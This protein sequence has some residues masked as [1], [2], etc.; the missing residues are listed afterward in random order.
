MDI[1]YKHTIYRIITEDLISHKMIIPFKKFIY[2]V[3]QGL[4]KK[5]YYDF[6]IFRLQSCNKELKETFRIFYYDCLKLHEKQPIVLSYLKTINVDDS[7]R[8]HSRIINE[9]TNNIQ[10]FK[11]K[12]KNN[13]VIKIFVKPIKDDELKLYSFLKAHLDKMICLSDGEDCGELKIIRNKIIRLENVTYKFGLHLLKKKFTIDAEKLI[14]EQKIDCNLSIADYKFKKTKK[15]IKQNK[16]NVFYIV[17]KH[18]YIIEYIKGEIGHEAKIFIFDPKKLDKD[19]TKSILIIYDHIDTTIKNMQFLKIYAFYEGFAQKN[20]LINKL[21]KLNLNH[22]ASCSTNKIIE[23]TQKNV[24]KYFI[25]TSRATVNFDTGYLMLTNYFVLLQNMYKDE[26]FF[27]KN[28]NFN[29]SYEEKNGSFQCSLDLPTVH[30]DFINI[31]SSYRLSKNDARKCASLKALEF[32]HSNGFMDDFLCPIKEKLINQN[33]IFFQTIFKVYN[34]KIIMKECDTEVTSAEILFDYT[35]EDINEQDTA[36]DLFFTQIET[37]GIDNLKLK[38][39]IFNIKNKYY[40]YHMKESN[41]TLTKIKTMFEK[42]HGV[43]LDAKEELY[44]NKFQLINFESKQAEVFKTYN[45]EMY[46]YEFS[47][48]KN[49]K[50]NGNSI[51]LGIAIGQSFTEKIKIQDFEIKNIQMMRI[52]EA[53]IKCLIFF[54]VILFM[55][56]FK[57]I[58]SVKGEVK[59]YCYFY[60]PL[61]NGKVDIEYILKFSSVDFLIGSV[62]ENYSSVHLKENFLYNPFTKNFYLFEKASERDI[63]EVEVFNKGEKSFYDYFEEKYNTKLLLKTGNNLLFDGFIY[64]GKES[65]ISNVL[66]AEIMQI[67]SIKKE[68]CANFKKSKKFI[69]LLEKACLS[70]EF[71]NKHDLIISDQITLQCFLAKDQEYDNYE[72][73]EFLGDSLLKFVAVKYIFL[74]DNDSLGNV[75]LRKDKF[76]SNETLFLIAKLL[77]IPSYFS[78]TKYSETL[79]QPPNLLMYIEN[80]QNKDLKLECENYIDYFEAKKLFQSKNVTYQE[81]KV[82]QED[83]RVKGLKTY[84]D[85]VEALIGAHFIEFG[86][87][88]GEE[89]IHAIGIFDYNKRSNIEQDKTLKPEVIQKNSIIKKQKNKMLNKENIAKYSV[90]YS[91]MKVFYDEYIESQSIKQMKELK[92]ILK[93]TEINEI[94]KILNYQFKYPGLIEKAMIHP[95]SHQNILGSNNFN[96]LEFLGDCALDIVVTEYIYN[97]YKAFDPEGMHCKR[98]SLVNNFSLARVLFKTNLNKYLHICFNNEHINVVKEKLKTDGENVNKAFGDVFESICGAILVDMNYCIVAFK[99]YIIDNLFC[100]IQVCADVT[101]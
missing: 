13:N 26:F 62:Y 19:I 77:Q 98:K 69:F 14:E 89:F 91:K 50:N 17:I 7:V 95:S 87:I 67:T 75:V 68:L 22:K 71:K 84:A 73:L 90:D 58:K 61:K 60:V 54:Q 10:S 56:N 100:H 41:F 39:V 38:E 28:L 81:K 37:Y 63:N 4:I 15:I 52:T 85:I 2:L 86:Y 64:N 72:R 3:R 36:K 6:V 27:L 99:S 65:G 97:T 16:E 1:L 5:E 48:G 78:F 79:F 24:E 43:I 18:H 82:P 94:E 92:N 25:P 11:C 35:D 51:N 83:D 57:R 44:K 74:T 21:L 70:F 46:I 80:L 32:L 49:K 101:R 23:Y 34:I 29:D 40:E 96:K 8:L 12:E 59:D 42:E 30:I 53:E 9:D 93:S 33:I 88:K 47:N 20:D 45:S 55:L 76:I 66:S 31:K